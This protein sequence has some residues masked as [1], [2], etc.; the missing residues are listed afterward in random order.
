MAG[1]ITAVALGVPWSVGRA[2]AA[3]SVDIWDRVALCESSGDWS[4]DTGNGYY[5]G[6][7][8]TSDT[9]L[10][11]GGGQYAPSAHLATKEQQIAVAEKVLAQQGP[12]AWPECSRQ[13]GLSQQGITAID[14]ADVVPTAVPAEADQAPVVPAVI[15]VQGAVIT[16]SYGE[17]GS[18]VA[19]YHTGVD[20]AIAIGMPVYAVSNGTIVSAGWQ[21]AYGNAIVIRHEDGH[22]TLYAHLSGVEVTVGQ[23]VT[24]GTEIGLS[25][26]TGNSTGPHLHFEVRTGDSYGT[27]IDPVAYLRSLGANP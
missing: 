3:T 20:F 16:T 18:W 21:G 5:G 4:A 19:G 25:G 27:D 23:L 15:P 8:F 2:T 14:N 17:S 9:W 7:Q 13:A 24:T 26:N 11:F 22:Y 10:E 1:L 6:L 12:N